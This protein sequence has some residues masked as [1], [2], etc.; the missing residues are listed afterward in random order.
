MFWADRISR[1]IIESINFKPYW[2]DDMFT[3][4]G[5]AHIGSLRGPL[6]HDLIYRALKD[7]KQDVTFTYVFN[8]FDPIDGL[9]PE[10]L[11]MFHNYLGFPLRTAPS[12]GPGFSSF[13]E[14]FANDFKRVLENLGIGARFLSSWDMYHEGKFNHVIQI[15]LDH[16]ETIQDIYQ[17]ISG[18][19]KR[20]AG[21]LPLQVI[22][23][24]CGKLGTTRIHDW[25]GKTVGYT[26]ELSMVKWAQGCGQKG[27][28]SPFDG[29]GKLPWK[30]D[31]PAH[32]KV[33]GV[34]VEGAGKDHSSAG[35][36]R[37]IAREL[38][39][40]VF[41]F[42]DPFN[43]PYEFFLIG[44]KKMSS[45]KG[46]GLKARDLTSLFPAPVGRFL[47]CRT[48]YRQAIEFDPMETMAVPDLF[49]EYDR[50]W[51]AYI[52]GSDENLSRAF[53]LSQIG[54]LPEKKKLFIP[55][56]KDIANYIQQNVDIHKK[57]EEIK[58]DLLTNTETEMLCERKNYAYLWIGKYA[59]T[60]YKLILSE[61]LP[62]QVKDLTESQ[63]KFLSGII[64]L[65]DKNFSA[66][67]LNL[68]LYNLAKEIQIDTKEAFAAIYMTFIGKT[69][70][71]RAAWFLLQY[72]KEQV[73]ERL[74]SVSLE[75]VGRNIKNII[76][77]ISRLDFLIIDKAVKEKYPSISIGM[78]MIRGVSISESNKDLE[79]ERKHVLYE[80]E[81]LTT[82]EIGKFY[83]VV[84]YRKLYKEMGIDWH[85][86]RP[87]P[88]ALLRRIAL[89]KGLYAV[90]TCVDAY[91]LVV[92]KNR[93][94]AGA[95]DANEIKFPTV[96]RFANAGDKI[97][98]L[99][100]KEPTIYT[101]KE[102]AYYDQ[103]GGY[104]IDFNFRDSQR[105][106]ITEKTRNLWINVD[107]VYDIT[108]TQ[109]EKTLHEAIQKIIQYCGGTVEFEGVA[110]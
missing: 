18:S 71:P 26:C 86:R 57:F 47:F 9:P 85:S 83:E 14:Y 51:K 74:E 64:P 15:A 58:G 68:G 107:G 54:K 97:L 44:G 25:D 99:G 20:E 104:N 23:P 101:N 106:M 41:D 16:A 82:E 53:E 92:V 59:P 3:P 98:L 78:A 30:V 21:W 45:S 96:L 32:W 48:D 39:K 42:P 75:T 22:C 69:Y 100:D 80:L 12:P 33:L 62:S 65:L 40:E 66:N 7:V 90:N 91:N 87:S 79:E 5:Y 77:V 95:F 93:V 31:W 60:E 35:G 19:K 1:E 29:N 70:G 43:L 11:K 46:L 27:R 49:D 17:R 8:D 81:T 109:V 103:E 73:I 84:S 36:S 55:R 24:K 105:T 52:N 76:K 6:V 4:S 72:P 10:L 102:L 61:S 110:E 67:E 34:T 56:F 38:C 28:I 37:D 88:E 94:S 50:C 13:A 63:K 89:K 2:V 108:P